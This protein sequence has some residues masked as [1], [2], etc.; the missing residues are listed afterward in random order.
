MTGVDRRT[1]LKAT[2]AAAIAMIAPN[3]FASTARKP[4]FGLSD[5]MLFRSYGGAGGPGVLSL[6]ELKTFKDHGIDSIR[7]WTYWNIIQPTPG[8]PLSGNGISHLA[9]QYEL[10][11]KAGM[12][13]NLNIMWAPSWSTEGKKTLETW[14]CMDHNNIPNFD[15]SKPECVSPPP[16]PTEHWARFTEEIARM[17]QPQYMGVWNEPQY[18]V[19]WPYRLAD[20]MPDHEYLSRMVQKPFYDAVKSAS[21][22]TLVVGPEETNPEFLHNQFRIEKQYG[23]LWDIISLHD[24]GDPDRGIRYPD[25]L[26]F[27]LDNWYKGVIA[28]FGNG[29]P[30]W[31]T[32]SG[33]N[34]LDEPGE[35][36]FRDYEAMIS[37]TIRR[38]TDAGHAGRREEWLGL[39]QEA[40]RYKKELSAIRAPKRVQMVDEYVGK[41]LARPNDALQIE[42]VYLHQIR[43]HPSFDPSCLQKDPDTGSLLFCDGEPTP[44][45]LRM[46]QYLHPPRR[47]A[48]RK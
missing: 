20:R 46:K 21:P 24:Y 39:L 13:V 10:A 40:D 48:V 34:A 30:V 38:A 33:I 11:Y 18:E 44:V 1:F 12:D 23:R 31:L 19:F 9:L 29:R 42:R 47:R 43:S 37:D 28:E 32:E 6:D 15:L 3:S 36:T 5:D 41:F 7:L 45:L 4:V 35:T 17:F 8:F 22:E 27:R 2:G 14:W 25:A 16:F 26:F